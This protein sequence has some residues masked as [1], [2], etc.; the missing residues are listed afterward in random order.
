MLCAVSYIATFSQT[1]EIKQSTFQLSLISPI[2]TNGRYSAEYTN[3]YSLNLL[4]GISKNEEKFAVSLIMQKA[5]RLRDYPTMSERKE[6]DYSG[7]GW[8]I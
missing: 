2:G 3:D 1:T 5:F 8:Q 6:K 7:L 4:V